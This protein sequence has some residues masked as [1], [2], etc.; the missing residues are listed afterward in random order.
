MTSQE[1]LSLNFAETL[2][3]IYS[4]LVNVSL[5]LIILVLAFI[6]RSKSPKASNLMIGSA[7]LF[8]LDYV[9]SIT[10]NFAIA[11]RFEIADYRKYY[12]LSSAF[13][14]AIHSVAVLLLAIAAVCGRRAPGSTKGTDLGNRADDNPNPFRTPSN[15]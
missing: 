15:S 8:S 9:F 6:Y 14:M 10:A 5:P 11:R 4:G 12:L 13:T 7:I 3:L 2:F 1:L